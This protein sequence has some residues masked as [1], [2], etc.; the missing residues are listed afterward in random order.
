MTV[1]KIGIDIGGTFT[2]LVMM[3][4]ETSLTL[5]VPSTPDNP[6]AAALQALQ[7]LREV[8]QVD[9]T[10]VEALAHGTTVATNALLQRR[11]GKTAL[12]TTA[13]FRDVLEIARLGRPPKA[14]Y[15]VHYQ[16]PEPIIPR[17]LRFEVDERINYRG[18]VERPLQQ[19]AV[20]ALAAALRQHGIE[21][22][23]ICLLYSFMDPSHERLVQTVIQEALPGVPVLCS[24]DILP[25]RREYERTS[26]TAISAYLAPTVTD[27]IEQMVRE[28]SAQGLTQQLYI[29]QSNGGLNTP[30][31]AV[32]SPGSLLLS[33]PAAGVV[34]AADIGV[35]AG[36]PNAISIDMGGTSFDVALIQDGQCLL[37]METRLDEA[38]FHVPML[39]IQTIGAG[40]GSMAWLDNAGRLR[41]GP[42]SAGAKPGPACYGQG[43]TAP[44]VTDANLLLGLIN[45][46][47]FLGGA[48]T[49]QPALA[50]QAVRDHIAGP[51]GMSVQDAAAG[52]VRIVNANMAGATRLV[53]VEKGHDPRDFALLA[54]GGAGPLHAVVI[55]E[56]LEI[57]WVVVPR[58]PGMTSAAGLVVAD[59]VHNFVQTSVAELSQVT[60][61]QLAQAFDALQQRADAR[62]EADGVPQLQRRHERS[63]DI[64]YVGQGYTLNIPL[65][66]MPIGPLAIKTLT[67]K[68]HERHESFYGFRADEEPVEMIN[69]RLRATGMLNKNTPA[70][71][72]PGARQPDAARLGER[73]AWV[74][75][76]QSLQRH[77]IYDR[78]RLTTGHVLTGPAIVEQIDS[79]TLI[80][81]GWICT[82]DGHHHLILGKEEWPAH[83]TR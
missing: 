31:T 38:A 32:A 47:H 35:R 76:S 73:E 39:D 27:Y 2:D 11:G 22:V 57:P 56:E 72:L 37:S 45:P 23:A 44:T 49:I 1:K 67:Q 36:F 12:I 15:D 34:A 24:S 70:P 82:V 43:G 40:G 19:D 51:L 29:M 18:E 42:Q 48:M 69:L 20:K 14:I 65:T 68:F 33:G 16:H 83:G 17:P 58:Y 8:H 28:V 79:T 3:D 21:S 46:A 64:K 74:E 55:A 52:I 59:I 61:G 5:K 10:T 26:T 53:S 25:E 54:F 9:L 75:A 81:P 50:E 63:L 13:G 6:G 66:D 77:A 7:Q 30:Q 60:P 4:G 78:S 71:Q 41:V 80:P 62:L